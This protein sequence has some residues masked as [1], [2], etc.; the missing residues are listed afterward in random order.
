MRFEVSRVLDTIEQRLTTDVTLAQA[1]V[2]LADVARF[3]DLDGGKGISLMRIGMVLDAFAQY[4][5]DGHAMLYPVVGRELL[6]DAGFTSKER[7]VLGRW[8]DDGRIEATP[9]T[10]DRVVEIADFT[11]MPIIACRDYRQFAERFG[12]VTTEPERLLRLSPRPG[13]AVLT[14]WIDG[15]PMPAES[16]RARATFAAPG[17]SEPPEDGPHRVF[18]A[19]SRQAQTRVSTRAIEPAAKPSGLGASL[20]A[21]LWSCP[22]MDCPSFS[23][24]RRIGQPVPRM[25]KGVAACP[26]HGEPLK[27]A[28]VRPAEYPV[29]VVI[30]DVVRLRFPVTG[31][32]PVTVGRSLD[33]PEDISLDLW[34][35]E[36]AS[37]WISK[38]HA[39]LDIV[40]GALRITDHGANGMLVWRRK[41]A[42]GAAESSRLYPG[43]S[44]TLGPHD[45]VELYT[46]VELVPGNRRV[47]G[48]GP[49]VASDVRSVL[50]DAPTVALRARDR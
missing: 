38:R 8:I 31:S 36:A 41:E 18:A 20:L 34:L 43:R 29:A 50:V 42:G 4:L 7:M 28:G 46:G 25:L 47:V 19:R 14:P 49:V 24:F 13:K 30:D 9:M 5:M 15:V 23:D 6:S 1:V 37:N 48:G 32:R 35:H 21:R 17:R 27:D 3:Q 39:R 44:A 33:D 10:G 40:D 16:T 12:W 26:R 45:S 11:G 22:E 2:D